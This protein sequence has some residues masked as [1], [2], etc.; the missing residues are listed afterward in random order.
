MGHYLAWVLD[1]LGQVG[2]GGIAAIV[3]MGGI[4]KTT[5]AVVAARQLQEEE[6]FPDGVVLVRCQYRTDP[7]EILRQVLT[8]FD[9]V[10]R[11]PEATELT[12]LSDAA[13]A[14]LKGKTALVVLDNVEPGLDVSKVVASLR[15]AGMKLLLTAR[16]TLPTDAVPAS[17]SRTLDLLSAEEAVEL[18]VSL[19]RDSRSEELSSK[20][21]PVVENLVDD[22]G[23][24][25]LA[26]KLAVAY[27]ASGRRD[28]EALERELADPKRVLDLP[29]DDETPEAVRRSFSRS[30]DGLSS[31]AAKLFAG[32]AAFPASEFGRQAA[33]ALGAGL[34]LE[35][36]EQSLHVLVVRALVEPS[37]N[38]ALPM[39]SDRER[40]RLH[41]LVRALSAG[42][43]GKWLPDEQQRGRLAVTTHLAGYAENHQS[44][45][46]VLAADV[47]NLAGSLEWAHRQGG[48]NW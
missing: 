48:R 47:A 35:H 20:Q 24:H 46:S 18:F 26:M 19:L 12:T 16:Q 33:I 34:T 6:R 31:D 23:R 2:S 43:F 36:P 30:L 21:Q 15:A 17:A 40:L 13:Q 11:A 42:L 29:G 28:L 38:L 3:G 1:R 4:G 7:A 8:R 27:A 22:L 25:P 10:R 14:S 5:L 44:D 39:E 45:D 32:L 37:T 9:L 41:P